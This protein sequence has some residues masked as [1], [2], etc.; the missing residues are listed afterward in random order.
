MVLSPGD[1]VGSYEVLAVIGAAGVGEVY[2]ALRM[3]GESKGSP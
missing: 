2:R 1:R 3:S